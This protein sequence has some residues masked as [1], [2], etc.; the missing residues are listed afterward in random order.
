VYCDTNSTFAGAFIAFISH[1]SVARVE[2]R[3]KSFDRR[4]LEERNMIL[5]SDGSPK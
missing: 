5:D 3:L 2:A 1:V 4:M